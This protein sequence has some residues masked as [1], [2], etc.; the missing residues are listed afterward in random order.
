MSLSSRRLISGLVVVLAIAPAARAQQQVTPHIGYVYPAG[1]RQGAALEVTIGGQFLDGVSQA[2]VSGAGVQATVVEHVKPIAK[3]Q[4]N[5]LKEKLQEL[6]K[7]TTTPEITKEIAEIRKKLAAFVRKPATPAIAETVTLRLTT[8][9]D[10]EPGPR[11]FRLR[12]P[13]GLTN[14]L[15]FCVGQLPEFSKKAAQGIASKEGSKG[16]KFRMEVKSSTAAA[17]AD[18][19]LPTIVNGQ[20]LPGGVDRYRFEARKGQRIVIAASARELIPY[21]ADAVPGWFQAAL[22]LYDA[23]GNEVAYADHYRFHPDPVLYYEI[24]EDGRYVIEIRDSIYRGREDFV[25]RIA[26][27]ELPFV[28]SIFPLGGRV[29]GQSTVELTGWNLPVASLTQEN[30]RRRPGVYPLSV[31]KGDHASNQLPFAVDTLP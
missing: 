15:V 10:A 9:A 14:P 3:G 18:L 31:R 27:G 2:F 26:V 30:E 12:T 29:G 7:K 19:T 16:A 20:I 21:L 22:T 4:A 17:P 5:K 13:A 1:A 28:T 24:P 11:E 8:A 6:Q 23:K 25:Y